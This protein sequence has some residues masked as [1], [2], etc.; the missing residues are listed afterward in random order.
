MERVIERQRKKR[1][2]KSRREGKDKTNMSVIL[3]LSEHLSY[4][5]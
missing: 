5:N 2:E 1:G 4:E 3:L